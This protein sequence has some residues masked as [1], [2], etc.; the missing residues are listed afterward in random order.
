M[1]T[2]PVPST[3]DDFIAEELEPEIDFHA[4]FLHRAKAHEL[5]AQAHREEAKALR[6]IWG[7]SKSADTQLGLA[8]SYEALAAS[9]HAK[10]QEFEK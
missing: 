5:T 2:A 4:Y 1:T 10:A 6:I 7:D 8:E 3:V 9:S